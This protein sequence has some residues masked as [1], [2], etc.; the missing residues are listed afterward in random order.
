M[1][2]LFIS[3]AGYRR[4]YDIGFLREKKKGQNL[5]LEREFEYSN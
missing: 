1:T 5:G 4:I 3:S 2:T